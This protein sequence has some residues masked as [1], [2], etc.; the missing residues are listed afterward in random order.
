M[1][2]YPLEENCSKLYNIS[3]GNENKYGILIARIQKF[4]SLHLIAS[5]LKQINFSLP[6]SIAR[7]IS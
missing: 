3:I 5:N 4:C 6:E 2:A 7:G 1:Q